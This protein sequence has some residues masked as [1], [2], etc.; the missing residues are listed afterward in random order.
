VRLSSQFTVD[1]PL[2][3]VWDA[4]VDLERVA[5]C[6]PGARVIEN[7]G[8]ERYRVGMTVKLGPM[9]LDYEGEVE[10]LERDAIAKR[11]RLAGSAREAR[12]QGTATSQVAFALTPLG[13]GTRADIALDVQLSGRAASLGQGM[14]QQV[15]AKLASEFS[16]NLA[17][18]CSGESPGAPALDAA[19]LLGA[20]AC[21]ALTAPRV[22]AVLLAIA[23]L[24]LLWVWS[25]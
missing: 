7:L 2:A 6:L 1:A 5:P 16:S 21:G 10:L 8:G 3:A 20:A 25:R 4:L 11:A 15:A 12:G 19:P 23:L 18:L 24:I 9:T 14:V 13:A 22:I 17:R